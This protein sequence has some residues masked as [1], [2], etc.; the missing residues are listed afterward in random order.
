MLN[1]FYSMTTGFVV[2]NWKLKIAGHPAEDTYSID[3]SE[4]IGA[5]FSITINVALSESVC[6]SVSSAVNVII[7]APVHPLE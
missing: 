7:S 2:E 4:K 3:K 6:S 1:L 5:S